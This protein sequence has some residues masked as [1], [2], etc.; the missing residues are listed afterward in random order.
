M[1]GLERTLA[2]L[3]GE[4]V[5]RLPFHPIIMRW[6]AQHAGVTY[7]DFCLDYRAKCEAMIR[8]ADDFDLDWV[9]VMSD[10]YAEASAFGL[11]IEYPENSLPIDVG[12]HLPDLRSARSLEPYRI[13][14]GHHRLLNRIAEVREFRRRVGGRLF[15]VGWV[16]GPVAEYADIRG[17]TDSAMDLL[18]DPEAVDCAME[19]IVECAL[20]FIR[21]QVE[22]GADCI[23]IGDAFCSQ[24][25]PALY[26]RFA[27]ERERRM[28]AEIH[29]LGAI[30][31]LHICGDTTPIL[32]DMIATGADI[33][34]VDHLVRDMT[35][36]ARLLG[37]GQVLSGKPDPV[38]TIQDGTP[39][40]I[41]AA[42]RESTAQAGGRCIVSA[43]CEIT[44]GTSAE[45]MRAFRVSAAFEP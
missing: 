17:V 27:W 13:E 7:R 3:G 14:D 2:F 35:P 15:I 31:K 26:R 41:A 1:N 4:P 6:A 43:G 8:C 19:V 33:V 32:P 5:D 21:A 20:G 24:I 44:P 40:S 9:T 10:P 45:N 30:A 23:G 42:V 16:E 22:A 12:G 29:R 37:P 18:D 38:S 34:D 39:D 25:G 11:Q 28:V 36:F